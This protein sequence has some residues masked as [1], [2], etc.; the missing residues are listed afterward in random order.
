MI[1]DNAK[2]D[3]AVNGN[4]K[5]SG[6]KIQATSKAFDILSSNIYT[7]KV[8]AVVREISC[9][10][11]DAHI[12]A[13]NSQPFNV[14]LPT[15]L[16]P[17]FSVRDFGTGLSDT[18]VREI[19]STY[20]CSTKTDSNA[21]IGAL[22]LGSKSPFSLVDSFTVKSYFNGTVSNYSCYRDDNGE[23]QVALLT[24]AATAEDN[25]LEVSL[26]A[27]DKQDE[28]REE[29]VRVYLYF[30]EIPNVNDKSV[31]SEIEE[32]KSEFIFSGEDF[33]L[34]K[35][36]GRAKAVMGGVAYDI[37]EEYDEL[38]LRGFIKFELGEVSFDAGRESLSLDDKTKE[39]I[40][41]KVQSV[42]ASLSDHAENQIKALPTAW[43][44][45][46]L[47]DQLGEGTIGG[48]IGRKMLEQYVL[49]VIPE[50]LNQINYFRRSWRSTQS[51]ATRRLPI[52]SDMEYFAYKPRMTARIRQ[53]MKTFNR[54]TLVLLTDE[55]IKITKIDPAVIQDLDV[56]PKVP[57]SSGQSGS[58]VRTFKLDMKQDWGKGRQFWD[59]HVVE[60]D[61][62]EKVYVELNRFEPVDGRVAYY[63]KR[64][65]ELLVH[66][67]SEGVP[68]PAVYGLKS[69]F[70]N[71]KKF[72][73]NS[74]WISL[75]DYLRR[76]I[77]KIAPSESMVYDDDQYRV[78]EAMFEHI[79]SPELS[80]WFDLA[81]VEKK[82]L[83][84][85]SGVALRLG[86]EPKENR[87]LDEFQNTFFDMYPML[88]FLARYDINEGT[89][90]LLADYIN[91][92]VKND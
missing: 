5:T 12:D 34:T 70:L 79:A 80:E 55:Q 77:S 49:P 7:H 72:T 84:H 57:R 85:V 13:G 66:L 25:G 56:L 19:F 71:T 2:Q 11:H 81:V 83:C 39:A 86:I 16:E 76:E 89:S 22:G 82:E 60:L 61:G 45:A 29:A 75:E 31:V 41:Q 28:F 1:L 15:A 65:K 87:I 50:G 3:V 9:N 88:R 67:E 73:K 51:T 10:A 20:F 32:L 48:K 59:E 4:F 53:Y 8:R 69:A 14:H 46:L 26:S 47:A 36:W 17:W 62:E 74:D 38:E 24:Q 18:D 42:L 40:Q 54:K 37:P 44:R 58:N 92:V 30:D 27:E 78:L 6:F 33:K 63:S 43:E 90:Q 68:V 21:F 23:P 64:I 35:G 52:G 91:G